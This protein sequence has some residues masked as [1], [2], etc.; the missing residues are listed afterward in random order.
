MSGAYGAGGFFAG[1]VLGVGVSGV[2]GCWGVVRC[3][4]HSLQCGVQSVA[5]VLSHPVS[6][7]DAGWEVCWHHA[8][9][10]CLRRCCIRWVVCSVRCC[11]DGRRQAHD[12]G[13]DSRDL[14]AA[15]VS[16]SVALYGVLSVAWRAAGAV[17]NSGH[18]H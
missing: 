6:V 10:L 2:G 18:V 11:C 15:W 12:D 1:V 4:N 14:L 7:A 3:C 17:G 8:L 13:L 9:R 16:L 5:V